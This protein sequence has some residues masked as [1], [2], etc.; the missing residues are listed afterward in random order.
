MILWRTKVFISNI[1]KKQ[2]PARLIAFGF[3]L[4]IFVGAFLLLLPIS[5]NSGENVS[6]I[7]ALFTSTSAVCV[8]GLTV[9]DTAD[10]FSVFGRTVIAILIQIGGLGVAS[11]GVSFV[12][13]TR[14]RVNFKERLLVKEAL[15]VDTSK[16]LVRLVK[17]ILVITIIIESLGVILNYF[18]FSKEY[19]PL[20]ALGVSVFHSIASFN[21]SGFDIFGG[22]KSMTGYAGNTS[23]NIITSALVILGGIGF[24]VIIDVLK[25]RSWKRLTLHSK[26]VIVTSGALLTVGT[27]IIWGTEDISFLGAFFH[28][29]SSR[30][31]GFAT[32]N[33]G[34]FTNAGLLFI[35]FLMFVGASPGSTGGGIKTTT[36]F[37]LL[38]AAKS[39]ALK[40]NSSAFRRKIPRLVITKAFIVAL[41]AAMVIFTGTFMLCIFEPDNT[42]MQNFFEEVSAFGTVGFSTGITPTLSLYSKLVITFT[43]FIGRLGPVT[44]ASLWIFKPDINL[45]YSEENIAI[46]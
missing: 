39:V 34:N 45:S 42:F 18:V 10:T 29:V 23:L 26:V 25:K 43:M 37:S 4:V 3:S 16:G 11:V 31:A 19:P 44:I 12:M 28:S 22:F 32:F 40:S 36:F 24:M 38:Q 6:L 1:I 17:S 15:N 27:L 5:V 35:C 30:T 46:G 13:L 7:N 14:K 9:T 33:T 8:T 41:M 2:S 20:S 21:N